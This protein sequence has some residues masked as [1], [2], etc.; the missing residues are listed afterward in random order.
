M[1]LVIHNRPDLEQ[2]R[3]DSHLSGADAW[4]VGEPLVV[5]IDRTLVRG[6][7]LAE[8][9]F[10][11]VRRNPLNLLRVIGWGLK[12]RQF[13]RRKVA[14]AVEVDPSA[15]PVNEELAAYLSERKGEGRRVVAI[16]AADE[17]TARKMMVR[18]S[19]IDEVIGRDAGG[20]LQG[21]ERAR[22]LKMR[23][24]DG[25]H[26]A[27]ESAD[28]LHVWRAS[29][30]VIL[31]EPKRTVAKAAQDLKP[32][33]A[34]FPA[35]PQ[36]KILAKSL[37]LHQWAKNSLVFAPLILAGFV[38]QVS[39]WSAAALAFAGLGL[40]ASAT[41]VINDL[42]DLPHDR[43]HR[44]KSKRPL[45]SGRLS[46]GKG[47]VLAALFMTGGLVLA[48]IAGLPVLLGVCGY[49]ALTLLYSASLKRIPFLDTLTLASLF[50][51]R[52]VIGIVAVAAPPSS[53]LLTFSM[54][55][56]LSLSLAKR[57][58]ELVPLQGLARGEIAGRGYRASDLPIVGAFGV[59]SA[60]ASI[61]LFLLYLHNEADVAS[62]FSS[63]DL[64]WVFPALLFLWL[65][66]I[67]IL[68]SRGEMDDDPVAFSV[69]DRVSIW[70]GA[71]SFVLF[72]VAI[73]GS[74]Q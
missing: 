58:T 59:A 63:T 52:L 62:T 39:A 45:A 24:P 28:D 49:V 10:S 34:Y 22:L 5:D 6:N 69:R 54:F 64:L 29:S 25:F 41:Y 33:S 18:F 74:L 31:V 48:G 61:V 3:K 2:V 72:A 30:G 68:C 13:L 47:V 44:S 40:T 56:F 4:T 16:T 12:G 17:N 43:K 55:L 8:N 57:F 19:F 1:S 38:G 27:G 14:D 35:V 73:G 15:L 20:A 11:L 7:V 21:A 46:I 51:L 71:S 65:T 53:W 36:W 26:Y 37:R 42:I 32:A 23:Y 9:I 66:R 60:I 70:I 50:T 67:W